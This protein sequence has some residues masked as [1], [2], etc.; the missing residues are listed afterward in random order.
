MMELNEVDGVTRVSMKAAAGIILNGISKAHQETLKDYHELLYKT[1]STRLLFDATQ[2][3][4][5]SF[6]EVAVNR[7]IDS[8]YRRFIN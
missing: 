8:D 3:V 1:L 6:G 2:P 7:L 5:G 4:N